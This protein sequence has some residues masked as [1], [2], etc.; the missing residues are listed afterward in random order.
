[1]TVMWIHNSKEE[2]PNLCTSDWQILLKHDKVLMIF[3]SQ[4]AA[5]M[6][7][8]WHLSY[9]TSSTILKHKLASVSVAWECCFQWETCLEETLMGASR[10]EQWALQPPSYLFPHI[11][12]FVKLGTVHVRIEYSD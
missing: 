7:C 2:A 12:Y 1:M 8:N 5:G 11:F 10:K 9:K 6:A 4:A 3:F